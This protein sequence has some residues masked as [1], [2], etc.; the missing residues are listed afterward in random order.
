MEPINIDKGKVAQKKFK[1]RNQ[2]KSAVIWCT[3]KENLEFMRV[4][5]LSLRRKCFPIV[6][7]TNENSNIFLRNLTTGRGLLIRILF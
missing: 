1:T 2:I 7:Q 5:L 6:Y 4:L 3:N